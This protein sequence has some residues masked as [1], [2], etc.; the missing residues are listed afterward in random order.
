MAPSLAA[1]A[2]TLADFLEVLSRY[3]GLVQSVSKPSNSKDGETL[4]PLDVF[5]LSTVPVRLDK[6]R[7]GGGEL[8]LTK[9]EV[10]RLI[11]WKL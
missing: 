7:E 10:D 1:D 4:E 2:I 6:V 11:R 3:D 5:R 9:M 8:Y